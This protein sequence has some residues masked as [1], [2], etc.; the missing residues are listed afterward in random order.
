MKERISL[1]SEEKCVRKF[2]F[3]RSQAI[4]LDSER[5]LPASLEVHLLI[6]FFWQPFFLISVETFTRLSSRGSVF[7][8]V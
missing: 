8:F 4:L 6:E 5:A 7:L 2:E 3:W 1:K